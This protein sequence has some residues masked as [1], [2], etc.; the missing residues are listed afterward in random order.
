MRAHIFH[1]I[2]WL[3]CRFPPSIS[4]NKCLRRRSEIATVSLSQPSI[5]NKHG[6][7]WREVWIARFLLK[8][9]RVHFKIALITTGRHFHKTAL[10]GL[11]LFYILLFNP[12]AAPAVKFPGWTMH[13]RVCKQ[14]IFRS[15][16]TSTFN[17]IH[18]YDKPFACQCKK[19]KKK[20]K[21]G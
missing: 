18:F 13:G 7:S 8:L 12:F 10:Q 5:P 16:S 9:H 17:A 21:R 2:Y 3:F 6:Y 20:K 15:Y 1:F 14:R 4:S 19:K 11:A